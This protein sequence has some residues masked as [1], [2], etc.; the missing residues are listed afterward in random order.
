LGL[1]PPSFKSDPIVEDS[2]LRI[3]EVATGLELPTTMA[4]IGNDDFLILEKEK[5]TVRR[6]VNSTLLEEP[7]L[8]LDVATEIDR[9]L[10]GIAT[11]PREQGK[12]YVF[13][14]YSELINASSNKFGEK[15]N[16]IANRLYRYEFIDGKLAHPTLLLELP[17]TPNRHP[18]G[19]LLIGTDRNVYLTVGD[20]NQNTTAQNNLTGGQPVGT[21][22]ILR[23]SVGGKPILKEDR[24]G[25]L[26]DDYP[27]N[28]YYAYGI[29]NSFGIDFDPVTGDLWDTENGESVG[30]EI[31]LVKSGFNS[32][33][34]KV[35]GVWA[36]TAG[37]RIEDEKYIFDSDEDLV[38]FDGKG[39]YSEPELSWF[40]NAGLT[41]LKF[42]NTS[43]YGKEYENDMFVGDFNNG[44]LYHFDLNEDRTELSLDGDLEDRVA[45]SRGE[46][47]SKIFGKGFIA[48][49]DMELS[50]DGYLYIL[51]L[52][53]SGD[54]CD[55]RLPNCVKYDSSVYGT[56]YRIYPIN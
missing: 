52:H 25:I 27:L 28:L 6:V 56:L 43:I 36:G 16:G 39:Q 48:I 15:E 29:R 22:G 21:S 4:F 10:L 41:A 31:N 50:P 45:D 24:T 19:Q 18:G 9:G 51:S 20:L 13:L 30:D 5:G 17:A 42:L 54:D 34:N 49:T 23:L 46:A 38:K 8:N 12:K 37:E 11:I 47:S 35:Q 3:E 7:V 1:E 53:Q 2:G 33:W 55:P 44:N 26:G 32:G 40:E 14:Y